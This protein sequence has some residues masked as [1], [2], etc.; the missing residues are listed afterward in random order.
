MTTMKRAS[1]VFNIKLCSMTGTAEQVRQISAVPKFDIKLI[2]PQFKFSYAINNY[3]VNNHNHLLVA[4]VIYCRKVT[5][6]VAFLSCQS[7]IDFSASKINSRS[8]QVHSDIY[9]YMEERPCRM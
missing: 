2:S 5:N 3:N 7:C 6:L 9:S 4:G 8:C 1:V